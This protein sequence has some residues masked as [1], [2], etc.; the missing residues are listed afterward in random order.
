MSWNWEV[1]L[2][3]WLFGFLGF[4]IGI[5]CTVICLAVDV[6]LSQFIGSLTATKVLAIATIVL[7]IATIVLAIATVV[8]AIVSNKYAK[9]TEKMLE[10]QRKTRKITEIEKQ[11]EKLYYPL[12]NILKNPR[13]RHNRYRINIDTKIGEYIDLKQIDE[14][15][16]YQH[17]VSDDLKDL[18]EKFI[19]TAFKGRNIDVGDFMVDVI[20]FD[21]IDESFSKLIEDDIEWLKEKLQL[22]KNS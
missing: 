8:L 2:K 10:E 18:L 21:I 11:L 9:S 19:E 13:S 5:V 14:I 3:S 6:D 17:L 20:N 15:V 1:F 12:M 7:A 4:L 22:I 16:P